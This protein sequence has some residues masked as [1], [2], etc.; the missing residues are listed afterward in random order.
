MKK[1]VII[2]I[3]ATLA[4]V[5]CQQE[6]FVVDC[7]PSGQ[8]VS[9]RVKAGMETDTPDSRVDISGLSTTWNA[10]DKIGVFAGSSN[11]NRCFAIES[12]S[13][14][15]QATFKGSMLPTGGTQT[16][17]AYYPYDPD[18]EDPTNWQPNYDG[19][20]YDGDFT[21][22][23]AGTNISKYLYM[24]V[25]PQSGFQITDGSDWPSGYHL[26]FGWSM[27][28]IVRYKISSTMSSDFSIDRIEFYSP[29]S[30]P[31]YI[32][33]ANISTGGLKAAGTDRIGVSLKNPLTMKADGASGTKYVHM[34][35]SQSQFGAGTDL[36][37]LVSGTLDGKYVRLIVP[38]NNVTSASNFANAKRT[39]INVS[40]T[41][42]LVCQASK[43]VSIGLKGIRSVAPE[44]TQDGYDWQ[45]GKIVWGDGNDEL[46]ASGIIHKYSS[47]SE[48]TASFSCWGTNNTV[49]FNSLEN[50]TSIDFSNF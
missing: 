5:S 6:D 28:T 35:S 36:Q 29:S 1:Q 14:S 33:I 9:L 30:S 17:F 3:L 41:D 16:L 15:K 13:G 23:G 11:F 25:P 8:L 7:A 49:K 22:D 24:A 20:I 12:G 50:I 27:S 18:F 2:C 26:S 39:T 45:P 32:P 34:A 42:A 40:L 21:E 31:F 4:A 48:H 44:F 37:V 46:Y 10:N 47:D 38:K 43:T 19:Q